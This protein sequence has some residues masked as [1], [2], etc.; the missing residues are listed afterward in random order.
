MPNGSPK[1]AVKQALEHLDKILQS[2]FFT[3]SKRCQEFLR[4]IVFETSE[5]RGDQIKERNIASA[6]FGKGTNF[7]PGDDSVVRVK[8]REV[9]KRLL[10]YYESTP[11][12]DLRIEI[13]LGG[14]VPVIHRAH[15]SIGQSPSQL[16]VAKAG[17]KPL[18]RRRFAWLLGGSVGA[19]GAAVISYPLLRQHTAPL[20]LLWRPV[21]ETKR[22]LLIFMPILKDQSGELTDRVGIGPAAILTHAANFLTEHSYP[23]HLRFGSE[24]T[25]SQLTEQPS[26]LLGGFS[27]GWTLQMTHDLRFEL[28]HGDGPLGPVVIDRRTNQT[29]KPVNLS[30]NH[31]YADQDYGI[32]C[33]LFDPASG[34]VV[35]IAAGITTFGTEGAADIFFDPKLLSDLLKQAPSNWQT[36]NFQAVIR[37]SIVGTTTSS[38]QVV[39]SYF[40]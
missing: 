3:P 30:A 35:L 22:P 28:I 2:P 12:S 33:R 36:K 21:F 13:P 6:V 11:D 38:H 23:Y 24:L 5:G 20:D 16:E 4:Y 9:R 1:I 39:A 19:L 31:L 14:Y 37:V 29:W 32:A 27:S 7:E 34:Q 8:A 25:F 10:E 18:G 26:L 17:V 15:E 40:W